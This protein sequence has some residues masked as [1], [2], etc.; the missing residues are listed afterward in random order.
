MS[1][2]TTLEFNHDYCPK[3]ES[4]AKELGI[5]LVGYMHSGD[6]S[7]LPQGVTFIESH[8]HSE[9]PRYPNGVAKIRESNPDGVK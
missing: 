3:D 8:H 9:K 2:R 7:Y 6:K 5:H 1:N 4:E